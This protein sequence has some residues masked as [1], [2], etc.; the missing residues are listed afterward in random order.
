VPDPSRVFDLAQG[1]GAVEPA[2]APAHKRTH[3]AHKPEATPQPPAQVYFPP[4][5]VDWQALTP[6]APPPLPGLARESFPGPLF[7]LPIYEA[8][9]TKYNV[10][11]QVLAAINEVESAW[12]KY[13]GPSS[14]GAVGWM[15]FMPSTWR[16]YGIDANG[17]GVTNPE[18]PVDA[19]F[20]AARY[21]H[22]AHADE[23][24]GRAIYAYNPANW[25]VDDVV[26]RAIA[27]GSIR[28]D[29]LTALVEKGRHQ[30]K[31][32]R[33]ATGSRGLIDRHAQ[34]YSFGQAM[35]LGDKRLRHHVL[36]D[37]AIRI[38]GCGRKDIAHKVIDRRILEVL[39][40][41]AGHGLHPTVTSLRCGHGYYT[42]SGN[43]SEHSSGDA[44]DISAI[45]GI[46]ILGHQGPDSITETT[47]R[48]LLKLGGAMKPHQ[49]ISLMTVEGAD[50]TFAMADHADHIH[51]GFAPRRPILGI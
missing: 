40:F 49:I 43:V 41:L 8:A 4:V 45:N 50:N 5:S 34:I 13:T 14:A 10:P 7:L 24:L 39:R 51:V 6:L 30:A 38:Y 11:W 29:V 25:Y 35:L 46:P 28:Q 3:R 1:S 15:Q 26:Q 22:A 12:G 18:D 2:P 36:T 23:D 33:R 32:I 17:D 21:L 9:A 31:A 48:A 42:K 20:S 44:V 19:I 27:L 47:L 16:E 37:D